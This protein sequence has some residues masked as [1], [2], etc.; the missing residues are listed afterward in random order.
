[1]RSVPQGYS[2]PIRTPRM[3]RVYKKDAS[4]NPCGTMDTA[5]FLSLL[6]RIAAETYTNFLHA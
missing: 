1:M 3:S 5:L 4:G 2:N 6:S